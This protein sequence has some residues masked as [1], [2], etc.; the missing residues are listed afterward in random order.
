MTIPATAFHAFRI[1]DD[2]AATAAASRTCR[3]TICRPARS[4][5]R[6]RIHPSTTRTRSPAPEK[7]KSCAAFRWSA[8]SMSPGTWSRRPTRDSGKAIAVLVTGCGLCETRDGG[9]SRVRADRIAVGDSAAGRAVL[10]EAMILGTAGFTAALRCTGCS[11]TGRRRN[12]SAARDGRYRRCRFA[13]RRHL[14][15]RRVRSACGQRQAGTRRLSPRHRRRPGTGTGRAGDHA[16][17]G[18]R[19]LRRWAG[20]RRRPDAGEPAGAD[21][22]VR[23]CRQRRTCGV[24]C[25]GRHGHAIHHPRRLAAW[26][27]LRRHRARHPGSGLAAPGERLEARAPGSHLH[28]RG[29]PG[30]SCPR[31]FATM[32]AGGSL[33][34]TLVTL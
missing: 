27:R 18:I 22:S 6:P 31:F 3:S 23:Q 5:S 29:R 26:R 10:R 16:A 30:R 8:A 2:A 1:H 17:T 4:S 21:R 11:T 9:Y 20:Q 24:P 25:T 19:T 32:L 15:S 33:G 7:A 14:Q 13:G 12:R 34:R 28:P